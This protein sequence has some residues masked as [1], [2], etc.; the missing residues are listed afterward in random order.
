MASSRKIKI[1]K[2]LVSIIFAGCLALPIYL[3]SSVENTNNRTAEIDTISALESFGFYLEEVSL[4]SNTRFRHLP[5]KL[6]PVFEPILPQIASMGASVS[7]CDFDNDGWNDFYTTNS[8][9]NSKNALFRNQGNGLFEEVAKAM[10]LAD[11]NQKGTGVSMGAVWADY[12]NDG[13]EDLF[14]YKWGRPVLFRNEGG[15]GFTDVTSRSGLPEWV[16]ANSAIWFDYNSDGLVD[17]FIGGYF[18]EDV[19]LWD[20][21]RTTVLTES[22]EYSQNG[23]RNYLMENLGNGAFRDVSSETGITSTRWT[24]AAGAADTDLDGFPELIIAN[25]YGIDEFYHNEKGERFREIGEDNAIGFAPKSG[26][27]VALGDTYNQGRFGIYISNITEE[28]ILLQGN[29]FWI[30]QL[31]NEKLVYRNL[32]RQHG[33][34]SG[35][36]SYCA[37]F[38]DLN[39]DGFL[40][41]YV[42]N[43]FISGNPGTNYWY[44]YSKVTGGNK[45]IISDI[46]KWPAMDGRSQSGYQEN[47]VWINTGKGFFYDVADYVTSDRTYDSRSVAMADLWNRG[48]LD[49]IVANQNDQLLL[50]KNHVDPERQWIAFQLEGSNSNRSA[51]GAIVKL[52]W[53]S[54]VQSQIV[55][56]GIGFSSQ[57]QRRIHFGLG[58]TATVD[59]VEVIWPGGA[60]QFLIKP[61][62]QKLHLIT[63][64]P[65]R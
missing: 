11:L 64:T 1:L 45:S 27:N 8:R 24:L 10:G 4:P 28:G 58:N 63:E 14:V 6:D 18:P 32:A 17:L 16:N 15:Q 12:N 55:S 42:A 60:K 29:N 52:W 2:L 62:I 43:G 34:E 65:S 30:P 54:Q 25:D 21:E 9:F 49:V 36:W 48:V 59:S 47:R 22:F 53:D 7:V 57:N 5:P 35:G 3:E 13:F 44:D 61:A 39:N 26:M 20:L 50:Y 31:E 37:Q 46:K 23:G 51:I 19:N 38:G 40:D 56:G 33:I 41:L